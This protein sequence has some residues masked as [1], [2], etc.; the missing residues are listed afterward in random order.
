MEASGYASIFISYSHSDSSWM[1]IFRKELRAALYDK[2]TVWCDE[3]I[4]GGTDWKDRLAVELHR[5]DV[6]LILA[7][8]DYLGSPWCRRE[9]QYIDSKFRG[10]KIKNVFW[11]QLK[12]CAWESTE[13][14]AFQSKS[15]VPGK[16]LSELEDERARDREIIDI[17]H[18]IC[19]SVESIAASLD[20]QL[21]F[22]QSIIGDQ[23]FERH[24]SIETLISD[25]GDFAVVC[26]GRDG[27]QQDVAI[28]VLRKSPIS[29]IL[30]NLEKTAIRRRE[31]RDPGF[32]QLYDSF[33]V[34]SPHGEHLVLVMEY[35]DGKR[36]SDAMKDEALK[37]RFTMDYTVTLIRRAAAAL[38]EL[39]E[40]ECGPDSSCSGINEL[41]YGPMIPRHLFYDHRLERLRF[42]ALSISNFSWDV[43]GWRK[44]AAW[45]DPNS[46]RYAAPEQIVAQPAAAKIDKRKLDQYML[47]QLAVEMLDGGPP[48]ASDALDDIGEERAE[49]FDQPLKNAGRWKFRNPQLEQ[50]ISRMLCRNQDGRWHDMEE[51]VTRLK[52]VEG[53]RRA[54]AK[55]GYMRWIDKDERFFQ[56]FYDRFFASETARKAESASKFRDRE[57]QHD[58]LKKAMAAVLNFHPG[59]E[60][61]SLRYVVEAHRNVGVTEGELNQFKSSFLD[62]LKDRLDNRVAPD[63]QM[64]D[65]KEA[66]YEA[67]QDLFD[68]V[69]H[70]FRQQGVK[71]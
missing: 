13:L 66:V 67:W 38:R 20:P 14:A 31:L 71:G 59:N 43:L 42:S 53:E 5:A 70:Y 57:Q 35:F 62:L 30:E 41:G 34:K 10:K 19:S 17:V 12:P 65:G 24:L 21:T 15:S 40:L 37:G 63:D 60:P 48:V 44:F 56:E 33:I 2:A 23:A 46:A 16:A 28:K 61:T 68:Q 25:E 9:L 18:E 11:V 51:I 1:Q 64:A 7:T 45:V 8:S 69:L 47:G 39:H 58:K 50:I 49:P 22:V 55:S 3:D 52:A 26:R 54:L 36:L 29:S 6:A 4:G 27:S 32:I